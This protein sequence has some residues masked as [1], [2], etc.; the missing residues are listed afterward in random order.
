MATS[1]KP[2]VVSIFPAPNRAVA[3]RRPLLYGICK[4]CRLIRTGYLLDNMLEDNKL[5]TNQSP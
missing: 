1:S 4:R 5:K 2:G 3:S